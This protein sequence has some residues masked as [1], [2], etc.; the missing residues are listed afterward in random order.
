MEAERWHRV[1]A[2]LQS[3]LQMPPTGWEDF[4]R[5]ECAE[6]SE[7]LQEVQS[8]LRAYQEPA[9]FLEQPL[10]N[11]GTQL[12]G[13]DFAAPLN[14]PMS[15]QIVSHYRVGAKLGSGGMGVVYQAEDTTLRRSVAMK[16]LPGEL[17]SHPAAFDRLRREARAASS[18][19]HSNICSIYE[20]G[21][22]MGQPFI[23]MQLLEGQTLQQWIEGLSNEAG[24]LRWLRSLELG[25]QIANGLD[26]AHRKHIVHRDIK[27]SNVFITSRNEAKILDFGVAKLI[28]NQTAPD[29]NDATP[30][31]LSVVE[32]N[33]TLLT[34]TGTRIGTAQYMSPEQI[35]GEELDARTDLFSL[36][37]VLY[38]MVTGRRAFSGDTWPAV[39]DSILQS[40]P[41]PVRHV[42]RSIPPELERIINKAIRKVRAERYTSAGELAGDLARLQNR[43]RRPKGR[44]F[45]LAAGAVLLAAGLV[46]GVFRERAGRLP[47]DMSLLAAKPRRSLAVLGF[48]NVAGNPADGWIST[49]LEEMIGTELASGHQLRIVPGEN[50]A[51]MKLDLALPVASGYGPDTLRKVRK[52]LDTD[53]IL[54]G[55]YVASGAQNLRVD[56]K[57]QDAQGGE[58]IGAVSE[59]GSKTQIA[60]LAAQAG[61]SL[62]AQ[63]GIS[64]VGSESTNKN[65]AT[66]PA[67]LDAARF[68]SE[69]LA[70]LRSFD[71]LAARDLLARAI[72]I[73]P[74]HALSHSSM[75]ESL[76]ALGYDKQAREEA[77]KAF[78]LSQS[79]P[80]DHQLL[81]EG[82][83][84][85]LVHDYPVALEVYRSL[86]KFFPD[87]LDVGLKL[88][89]SQIHGAL[90]KEALKTVEQLRHLSGGDGKDAR[91]DL[92]ESDTR[93]ALG[94]FRRAQQ[95]ASAAVAKARSQ[96]SDLLE[97]Q[98]HQREAWAWERLGDAE[99]AFSSYSKAHDRAQAAGNMRA[100]AS[101]LTV[102]ATVLYDKGD[103]EGARKLYT[104]SLATARRIGAESLVSIDDTNI[105]NVLYDQGKLAEA[106]D[107]YQ[108]GLEID[109]LTDD[110]RGL[111]S[112]FGSLA[113]VL[114]GM[115]DLPA[116]TR[117]QEQALQVFREVGD[118]RGEASTLTNLGSVLLDRG[119]LEPAKLKFAEAMTLFQQSGFRRGRGFSLIG[120]ADILREEDRLPEARSV[121]LEN[122]ALRKELKD[123][124]GVAESQL[125]LA[126]IRLEQGDA[127]EAGKLARG[128][129][130]QFARQKSLAAGC[131]ANALLGRAQL[132]QGNLQSA[133]SATDLA[134]ALCERSQDWGARF[135]SALAGALVKSKIGSSEDASQML[136]WVQRESRQKGYV[137]YELQAELLRG[138]V[139]IESG[140]ALKGQ[141][142]LRDLEQ[143]AQ[144]K[145]YTLIARKARSAFR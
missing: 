8:L 5:K 31:S 115:G 42:D 139:E 30:E 45:V 144:I 16:F 21:E 69:G 28:G 142:R 89:E 87:D 76:S 125:Q 95:I 61:S 12:A 37:L 107:F 90:S 123:E 68:Y 112:D 18:L 118:K 106:R 25:I 140:L 124:S 65:R 74:G 79:L 96:G 66:L 120:I 15:G 50:V 47:K 92:V 127:A 48:R 93:A 109:R 121:A 113:N 13:F 135:E 103:L 141:S 32:G 81:I 3:V 7:L 55:S 85:E 101:A 99:K 132:A 102:G 117:M 78:D 88:A 111:A 108:Q 143:K 138:R 133:Q 84:R 128:A 119:E 134:K 10:A 26:A 104:E 36:G 6:D 72:A 126:A 75:A 145:G 91:I 38:E 83:Y 11:L 80:R 22:Y 39:C 43:V 86:W 54:Q 51:R 137:S 130:E 34:E 136:E 35:R 73:E 114:Q 64:P 4:L 33:A 129:A 1:D 9:P 52:N 23:V 20:F 27:P 24:K 59:N 71:A 77:K 131:T 82:R 60:T 100:A 57:I 41:T 110:K 53:L 2:L 29:S 122:I 94:D 17:V 105:G 63:L 56:L 70:K 62:R 19:D 58:T 46:V 116:A 14:Q 97:A 98:G 67:N 49:A 44:R 40:D